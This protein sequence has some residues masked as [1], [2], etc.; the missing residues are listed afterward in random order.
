MCT[1]I[2]KKMC[3]VFCLPGII[4][5]FPLFALLGV[6]LPQFSS[7]SKA[8][9]LHTDSLRINLYQLIYVILFPTPPPV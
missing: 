9:P 3:T 8:T 7:C 5:I 4:F 1:H 2:C 6:N